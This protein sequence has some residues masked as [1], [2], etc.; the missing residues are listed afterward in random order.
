MGIKTNDK[1]LVSFDRHQIENFQEGISWKEGY[2]HVKLPWFP[3]KISQVP[4][5]PF[6][7]LKVLDRTMEHL[8]RKGLL[9]KYEEVFD[10]QLNDGIIEEINVSP[11]DY[12]NY[13]WIPHRPVIRTD[14]QVTT[15]E[16]D[17]NRFCFFWKRGSKLVYYRYKTIVFGYTSSPFILNY[18]MKHHAKMYPEDKCR[19]ILEN[20]FYVDNLIISGHNIDEIQELYSLCSSRM[21][22]GGFTLRSWNSNSLELRKIMEAEGRLVEHNCIEEKVLGYRYYVYSDTLSLA[23]CSVELLLTLKEKFCLRSLNF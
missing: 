8:N 6:I 9:S 12:D 22:E 5:N 20:N 4:S 1:E 13:T 19:E 14:E 23:P 17:K 10:N 15:K 7:A 3:E 21:Q 16:Y 2:Y 18:V 11:S